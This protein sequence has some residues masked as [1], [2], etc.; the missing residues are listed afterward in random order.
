VALSAMNMFICNIEYG[1]LEIEK[2]R[3][4]LSPNN[5][6]K[7]SDFIEWYRKKAVSD[8]RRLDE[9]AERKRQRLLQNMA[10]DVEAVKKHT[11]PQATNKAGFWTNI[12]SRRDLFCRRAF[13][14]PP[15]LGRF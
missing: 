5:R 9:L 4:Y 12:E 13:C 1:Y 3:E 10:K 6:R 8:Q 14:W 2:A 11:N 7:I 15:I